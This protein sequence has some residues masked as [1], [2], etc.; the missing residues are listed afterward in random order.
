MALYAFD[1]TW[2]EAKTTEDP[3][4]QNTNVVR[5]FNTYAKNSPPESNFYVAGVGTRYDA[6]GRVLGGAFGLGELPRIKEA[7]AHLCRAW[8]AGDTTIDV[9]G[10]SRGAATTLDFCHY[11]QQRGIRHPETDAL[12]EPDPLIRFLGV[13]DIVAAFGLANLGNEVLNIGHHL[14]LPQKNLQFCYH[15][16]ALDERRLSFLPTR[17]P[18]ACEVWFRGVHSDIGGGNGN[19]GLNDITLRW[20]FRKAQA[21]G[22]PITDADIDALQPELTEPKPTK[23]LKVAIRAVSSTDRR[24]HTVTRLEGWTNPPDTCPVEAEADERTASAVGASGIELLPIEVR[25]RIAAMWESADQVAHEQGFNLDH[26]RAWLL[27]LFEG[28][29]ILVT[30]EAELARARANVGVLISAA[31]ANARRRDF[32]VLSEFFLN[33]ALFALPHL[34]PVRD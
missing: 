32:R 23:R 28:R 9:I 4:Y 19:R 31:A 24:H 6:I 11:L 10:F 16:L 14:S 30:N 8:T 34:F 13:W 7:H 5:F 18:G 25:R 1:G 12:V 26:A 17:L 3:G 21:S 29:V 20:M 15:A 2:N 33:E 22:L 27:N